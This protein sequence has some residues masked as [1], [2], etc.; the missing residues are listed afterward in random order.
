[1]R[2]RIASGII[3]NMKAIGYV[4]VSSDKQENSADAQEKRIRA[5]C[6]LHGM[7]LISV[8]VDQDEFSGDLDRPG[9]QRVIELVRAK[10]VD[11]V[12]IA[13]LDRLSRSTRDTSDLMDMFKKTGVKIIDIAQTL[14]MTCAIGRFIV[15]VRAA[16]AEYEREMIGERTSE[17]LQNLKAQGFPAGPAPYGY[18]AQ[19]R[20]EAEKKSKIRKPL[21]KNADEQAALQIMMAARRGDYEATARVLNSEGFR[22]RAGGMWTRMSVYRIIQSLKKVAA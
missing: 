19:P 4:R 17:G 8:E 10:Q 1:M 6:L 5:Y 15:N 13:K 21:L 7:D 9:V 16:V 12:V 2:Y 22:T 20:T 18:T 3:T 11:A 14:D